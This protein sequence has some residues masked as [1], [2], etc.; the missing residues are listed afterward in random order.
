MTAAVQAVAPRLGTL[1]AHWAS[2]ET[3]TDS[4]IARSIAMAAYGQSS[5]IVHTAWRGL[6]CAVTCLSCQGL[7]RLW[8]RPWTCRLPSGWLCAEYAHVPITQDKAGKRHDGRDHGGLIALSKVNLST[9]VAC[10]FSAF[11][12][13]LTLDLGIHLR[14]E[15]HGQDRQ[16]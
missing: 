6:H 11:L 4:P 9:A 7:H 16:I 1:S 3:I 15:Q 13:R 5:L 12:M 8:R 2:A 14:S 10:S